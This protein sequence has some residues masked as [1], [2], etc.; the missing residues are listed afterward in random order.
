MAFTL[1]T[2]NVKNLLEPRAE[3]DRALLSLK[4]DAIAETL[5]E[6]DADVVGLQ[7]VGPPEL[8]HDV[9][10]RLP[11]LGYAEP[12]L[13]TADARGIRCA[14]LSRLP[15]L[16]SRVETAAALPFP[17]FRT[18]DPPP[19]GSRIPL[20]RGV[21]RARIATG[22]GPVDV[23]VVH[24]KSPLPVPL[25]DAAGV[26]VEAASAHERA[27]GTL[28]SL[29]WRAAEALHARQLVDAILSA[30][31]DARVAVAGDFNDGPDSPVVRILRGV[32]G[33]VHA[34]VRGDDPTVLAD[35]AAGIAPEARFSTFHAGVPSHIDHVLATRPL[36]VRL[37]D[38]RILNAA[39]RDHG[40]FDP[41]HEEP[42]TA[43]SDHAPLVV[44][45][46]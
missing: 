12:V 1:A 41:D 11:I 3:S 5:R 9:I 2:F 28:R 21:V 45:F 32:G 16:E 14:L 39:L 8:L 15:I 46:E 30:T 34:G 36:G 26:A 24:F 33:D 29:V 44:R 37:A 4:L 17:V 35:C 10:R 42:L 22:L 23:L 40:A 18:G 6:C 27:E 7:E 25:R 13:G 38:A 20:R 19:F 31:P 43:D